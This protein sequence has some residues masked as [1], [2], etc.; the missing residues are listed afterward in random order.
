[1]RNLPFFLIQSL[2][3]CLLSKSEYALGFGGFITIPFLFVCKI[4]NIKY[5]L[6]EANAI[7]G[8]ANIFLTKNAQDIFTTFEETKKI[9]EKKFKNI[10]H[11]GLPI[12]SLKNIN[13]FL[14][15]TKKH[16][17]NM[18]ITTDASKK[19]NRSIKL[20]SNILKP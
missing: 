15:N 19:L 7:M 6:H 3:I 17:I 18:I 11:V 16:E 1:M 13:N 5:G 9:N 20:V 12:R 2:R 8:N 4:L 10:H 14:L